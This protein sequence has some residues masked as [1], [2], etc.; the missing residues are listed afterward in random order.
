M[1]NKFN[2]INSKIYFS[3]LYIL[4]YFKINYIKNYALLLKYVLLLLNYILKINYY[5]NM[6]FIIIYLYMRN[7]TKNYEYFLN[8]VYYLHL[9]NFDLLLIF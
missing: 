1:S 2:R 6:L 7:L 5:I 4:C 9:K 8:K 3:T